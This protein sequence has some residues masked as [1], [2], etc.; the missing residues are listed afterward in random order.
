MIKSQIAIVA[1]V[2]GGCSLPV[3]AY[4]GDPQEV[5]ETY[6]RP[7]VVSA[8]RSSGS[9]MPQ[10]RLEL[11][12]LRRAIAPQ[13]GDWIVCARVLRDDRQVYV[14]TFL[15]DRAVISSREAVIID[16]CPDQHYAPI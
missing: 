6:F 3:P 4:Q 16:R 12:G 10:A 13:A 15:R 14:A 7:L 5:V 1:L 2:V 8:L 9:Q 11:S